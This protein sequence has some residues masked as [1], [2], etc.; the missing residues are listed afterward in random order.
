MSVE[1]GPG[2]DIG[3]GGRVSMSRRLQSR[4]K[5]R[6]APQDVSGEEASGGQKQEPQNHG[7]GALTQ[8]QGSEKVSQGKRRK[9]LAKPRRKG[10][11]AG[12]RASVNLGGVTC[13]GK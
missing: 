10:G 13:F 3:D 11:H 8:A 7:G 6:R 1:Q 2:L 9:G 5:G 4:E 12:L